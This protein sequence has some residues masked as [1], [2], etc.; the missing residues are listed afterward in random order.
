MLLILS[1]C[2]EVLP[3]DG[4]ALL[5]ER[6][7]HEV[8]EGDLVAQILATIHSQP[9]TRE[10]LSIALGNNTVDTA[11]DGLLDLLIRDGLLEEIDPTVPVEVFE[12]WRA[13]PYSLRDIRCTLA[14]QGVTL[15][16]DTPEVQQAL[17]RW[18]ICTGGDTLT[19]VETKN[20]VSSKLAALNAAHW[21][22]GKPWMV[23]DTTGLQVAGFIP[24]KTGCWHCFRQSI[25]HNRPW[26]AQVSS[27]EPAP[28]DRA[29]F[30]EGIARTVFEWLIDG[31]EIAG[32]LS[33]FQG[34]HKQ[35]SYHP[36][37]Q[38]PH[39]PVC[40]TPPN[41]T[42]SFDAFTHQAI[43]A[44][45][46][47]GKRTDAV[48]AVHAYEHLIDPVTGYL[49]NPQILPAV[50][51]TMGYTAVIQ[52]NMVKA[53]TA[54]NQLRINAQGRSIGKGHTPETARAS[55]IFEGLERFSGIW[56]ADIPFVRSTA[57]TLDGDAVSL[58]KLA[59]YSPQ[60]YADRQAWNASRTFPMLQMPAP[61]CETQERDW[62]QGFSVVSHSTVFLPAGYCFYGY[63]GE[64]GFLCDSNGCAAGSGYDD[65]ILAG[66]LEL[67]ERDAI[68]LWWYNMAARPGVCPKQSIPA[69]QTQQKAL[70]KA[71]WQLDVLDLTTD[72]GI[73]VIACIARNTHNPAQMAIGFGCHWSKSKAIESALMEV[74]QVRT[75]RA[76]GSHPAPLFDRQI[77]KDA[78]WMYP[79]S[80]TAQNQNKNDWPALGVL[81]DRLAEK[82]FDVIVVDQT[83]PDI[84]LPVV[85]VVVPGLCHHWRRLGTTRLYTA[86]VDMGWRKKQHTESSLN[87]AN[88]LL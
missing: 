80:H 58:H 46:Q 10:S 45:K 7:G 13:T 21:T 60:Q 22:S 50:D 65:A 83:H 75:V 37:T 25:L 43:Q 71:G 59:G 40:G 68:A 88:L 8:I 56:R 14:E 70:E 39:C 49:R 17:Q 57:Q 28:L 69:L 86:P 51:S 35:A 38:K 9:C 55:A 77:T 12:K 15:H 48:Q 32:T 36:F 41:P 42:A 11:L 52:H 81:V 30:L 67:L 26:E 73:P 24:G 20:M 4:G 27:Q 19:I 2:V 29:V 34:I 44:L 84:G 47:Q 66:L 53:G 76:L 72:I 78:R 31:A 16:T 61:V 6:D 5:I 85:R 74:N 54:L 62:V 79:V 87:Q 82:G 33:Q 64:D 63:P 3:L 18:G 23:V 1:N